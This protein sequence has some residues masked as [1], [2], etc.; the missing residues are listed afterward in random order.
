[1]LLPDGTNGCVVCFGMSAR[2]YMCVCAR[3]RVCVCMC[4]C[5][6]ICVWHE[7]VDMKEN[8][9][10]DF[11]Q[12]VLPSASRVLHLQLQLAAAASAVDASSRWL[13]HLSLLSAFCRLS[14]CVCTTG[15][16]HVCILVYVCARVLLYV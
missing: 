4:L 16:S 5:V 3:T 8:L 6:Y 11:F 7:N 14:V 10:V 13:F 2:A 12:I 1:V 15:L 9:S